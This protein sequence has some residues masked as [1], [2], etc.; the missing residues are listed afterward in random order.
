VARVSSAPAASAAV[1]QDEEPLLHP[2]VDE[3]WFQ[4]LSEER[5]AAFH[6]DFRGRVERALEQFRRHDRRLSVD[7]VQTG[8]LFLGFDL[9]CPF[10]GLG[11]A[12]MA[13]AIGNL[14][15]SVLTLLDAGRVSSGSFGLLTFFL[16]Q[17][18]SR[19]GLTGVH[20]FFFMPVGILAAA[21]GL[22]RENAD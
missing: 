2:E 21:Q 8:L 1:G 3:A 22:R 16:F 9:L 17:W 19:D 7:A 15:G 14:L 5:Q 10:G 18:I 11:T 20:L 12:F 4:A 13:L 6:D